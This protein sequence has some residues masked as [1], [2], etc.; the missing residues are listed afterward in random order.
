M[1]LMEW[2]MASYRILVTPGK[3]IPNP[4]DRGPR[5]HS[6]FG[7]GRTPATPI[8]NTKNAEQQI[9]SHHVHGRRPGAAT[10]HDGRSVA[11]AD[12]LEMALK[13]LG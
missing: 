3:S 5:R 7:V 1:I 9:H 8:E 10:T 2:G 11:V 4:D 13:P 6:S 12:E